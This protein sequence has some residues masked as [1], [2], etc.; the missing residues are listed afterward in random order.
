MP[1]RTRDHEHGNLEA[2]RVIVADPGKVQGSAWL[3]DWARRT[4][5]RHE[6]S[7]E[8]PTRQLFLVSTFKDSAQDE[9]PACS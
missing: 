8:L 5:A 2:A 3:L 6:A 4:V 9:P 7:A 1:R